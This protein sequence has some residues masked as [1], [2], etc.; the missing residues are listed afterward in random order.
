M[1]IASRPL[2]DRG[3]YLAAELLTLGIVILV[4]LSLAHFVAVGSAPFVESVPISAELHHLPEYAALSLTRSL[5]ALIIS[6]SFAIF[7]GTVAARSERNERLMIPVLDVL[8]SLP[9]LTFLPGFVLALTS[10]FPHSRWGLELSCILMI[11]TGQVWNLVFAYYESQRTLNPELKEY[12]SVARLSPMERLTRLDLPSALSPLV[13]NGMMSMAGGWFF[14]TLCEGFVL[15]DKNYRLPGLGSFLSVTFEQQQYSAFIAGLICLV[16]MVWGV[17]FLL[18]RPLIAWSSQYRESGESDSSRAERSLFLELLRKSKLSQTVGDAWS[19]TLTHMRDFVRRKKI[20][21]GVL[22]N[23]TVDLGQL[24]SG[25]RLMSNPTQL[26]EAKTKARL[27]EQIRAFARWF[28]GFLVGGVVFLL[29][30]ALP[31]VAANMATVTRSDWLE[32]TNAL[33]L[34]FIK[35][36]GVIVFATLWTVP[37][38]LWVGKSPKVSRYVAPVIQNLAAF[39]APVVYPLIAMSLAK[40]NMNAVFVATLLMTIG[41]QWYML[42]NVISG[43]SRIPTELQTVAKVFRFSLYDRFTKLYFPAIFPSLL[44]GWITA[45]GGA[46]NASI[47]AEIV[48]FPGG[49]LRAPGIGAEITEATTHG[50]YQRL[51]AAIIVITIALIILNRTVWR[52]LHQHSEFLKQ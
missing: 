31:N 44:T 34:T 37:V 43:A 22:L 40:S 25:W 27:G 18:W 47:V 52:T 4:G 8:Q 15:G 50:H 33:A 20:N 26:I 38:G 36:L 46:W 28:S 41:N 45:A 30:P 29:L 51:V 9:V 14:L 32:L 42:F 1:R 24:K 16:L 39:P 11:V 35:V 21:S 19:V 12:A 13:Y 17:D 48:D 23:T 3:S 7:Y 10:L 2:V 5:I 6:Y 49:R